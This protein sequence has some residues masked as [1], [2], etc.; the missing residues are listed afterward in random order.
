MVE[1]LNLFLIAFLLQLFSTSA[2]TATSFPIFHHG[3]QTILHLTQRMK[4]NG[5]HGGYYSPNK[6]LLSA[7]NQSFNRM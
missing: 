1:H 5:M 2:F 6:T 3:E 7:L 4:R